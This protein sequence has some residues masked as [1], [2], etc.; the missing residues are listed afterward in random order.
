MNGTIGAVDILVGSLATL[1]A[2]WL[3]RKLRFN[4]WLVPL[5]PVLVNAVV[6]GLELYFMLH[7][8]IWWVQI[9]LIAA[10]EAV[11]CYGLGMPLLL[12]LE[13]RRNIFS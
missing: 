8:Y 1:A 3:S 7:L 2:A 12:I 6:V 4:K 9:L 10:G 13:K 5:P 11:A